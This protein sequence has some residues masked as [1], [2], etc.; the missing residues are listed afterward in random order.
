MA[1]VIAPATGG[2]SVHERIIHIVHTQ[3]EL[4]IILG[5]VM[6]AYRGAASVLAAVNIVQLH[7]GIGEMQ[8]LYALATGRGFVT[9][10]GCTTADLCGFDFIF[11]R[12]WI[13][14]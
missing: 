12:A 9:F 5:G 14:D 4:R 8:I 13:W 11:D 7:E 6:D 10:N 3:S 1:F 2:G